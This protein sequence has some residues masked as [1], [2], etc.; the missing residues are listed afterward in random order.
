MMPR[1]E[2][3]SK[4]HADNWVAASDAELIEYC[5]RSSWNCYDLLTFDI[6]GEGTVK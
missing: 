4:G 6:W 2:T 1:L 3:V 5:H